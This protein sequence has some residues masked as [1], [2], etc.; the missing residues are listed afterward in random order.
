[1]PFGSPRLPTQVV[2]VVPRSKAAQSAGTITTIDAPAI[3]SAPTSACSATPATQPPAAQPLPRPTPPTARLN[4][5][6]NNVSGRSAATEKDCSLFVHIPMHADGLKHMNNTSSSVYAPLHVPRFKSLLASHPDPQFSGYVVSGLTKGFNIGF[7]GPDRTVIANNLRSATDH[8]QHITEYLKTCCSDGQ[9]AG[10][11]QSQPF[12]SMRCSGLGVVPKK[13]GKLRVIRHLSAPPGTSVS[14][15]ISREDFSLRYLRV[16]DAVCHILHYGRG[17]LLTKLDIRNAFRL[18][19]VRPEDYHLLGIHWQ[20]KFY[21]EKVL[22]FGLRS[23]PYIFDRVATV[24]EWIIKSHFSIDALLHY[25]DDFLAVAPPCLSLASKQRDVIVQAFNYLQVPLATE[26]LEVPVTTLT[27]LGITLD[28]VKMEARLPDDKLQELRALLDTL[29]ATRRT[30]AAK[31]DSFLGKL[32]FAA[33]VV[34]PGRT[35]TRRLWDTAKRF[36]KVP[37]HYSVTLDNESFQDIKW[38]KLLL[39]SWNGK[40]LFLYQNEI[41]ATERGLVRDASGSIGWGAYFASLGRWLQGRWSA[42]EATQ[43]IQYKELFAVL[44]ACFTWGHHWPRHRIR[45]HCDNSAVVACLAS[46][47][48]KSPPVMSLLRRLFLVCAKYN[49]T[50]AAQ[51][52]PGSS[53]TIADAL[54]RFRL[55]EFRRLAPEARAAADTWV[56][57]PELI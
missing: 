35:F 1:M 38:W 41:A 54:S 10:P 56:P 22:P 9:T 21:Y 8:T 57:P 13:N 25:L 36:H 46:G 12:P 17:A 18:I 44:A 31:L 48:C 47:T 11:F 40:C 51:H 16:D 27:F 50:V 33:S 6:A 37:R 4:Q 26:K 14:D 24:I 30:S 29:S 49:F 53:N 39:D 43:S 5:V 2:P 34:L 42:E 20:D 15:G 23:S 19:P 32:A 28:T 55:Q 7:V 45:F 52:L 3:A